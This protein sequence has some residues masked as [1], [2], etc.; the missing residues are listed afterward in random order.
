MLRKPVRGKVAIAEVEPLASAEV[1][2]TCGGENPNCMHCDGLGIIKGRRSPPVVHRSE[3]QIVR[4]AAEEGKRTSSSSA[5]TMDRFRAMCLSHLQRL[6]PGHHCNVGFASKYPYYLLTPGAI[7]FRTN[8]IMAEAKG[9]V[10]S[11]T[12]HDPDHAD[13][14][15]HGRTAVGTKR[16]DAKIEYDYAGR[17]LSTTYAEPILI[18]PEIAAKPMTPLTAALEKLEARAQAKAER[19]KRNNAKKHKPKAV[20]GSKPNAPSERQNPKGKEKGTPPQAKP[21]MP[22]NDILGAK[23]RE[24]FE[25]QADHRYHSDERELDAT[26]GMHTFREYGTGQ[27]GSAPSHDD[28]DE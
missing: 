13:F 4:Q 20:G 12:W 27:F 3:A 19:G 2:C 10:V 9:T 22:I 5:M 28:Y 24:A 18:K 6:K 25:E 26:R 1:P 8:D 21:R 11:V 15:I 7:A 23:L 16:I 17:I 14:V